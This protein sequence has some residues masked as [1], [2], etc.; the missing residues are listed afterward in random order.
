VGGIL[1]GSSIRIAIN[2]VLHQHT[3]EN[4]TT[5]EKA[6]IVIILYVYGKYIY[7]SG[8]CLCKYSSFTNIK[9]ILNMHTDK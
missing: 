8:Y 1:S 2:A 3:I 6:N 7:G 9:G 4:K 5:L